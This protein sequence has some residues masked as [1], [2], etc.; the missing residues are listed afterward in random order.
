MELA[1]ARVLPL[2]RAQLGGAAEAAHHERAAH[3]LLVAIL[4]AELERLE[5]RL[6][7]SA[8]ELAS[9]ILALFNG[10]ALRH[11]TNPQVEDDALLDVT[12]TFLMQAITGTPARD[13]ASAG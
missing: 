10:I 8:E 4:E 11:T 2:R 12:M 13:R 9:I 1:V 6:D 5:S 7:M 3:E